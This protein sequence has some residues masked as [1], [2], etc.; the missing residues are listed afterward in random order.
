MT[1]HSG[2]PDPAEALQRT[3]SEHGHLIQA[4]GSTLCSLLD[5]Q[6]QVSQQLEQLT[7][8][9]QHT[10]GVMPA[11]PPEGAEAPPESQHLPHSRE[12]VCPSP[13]KFSGESALKTMTNTSTINFKFASAQRERKMPQ[14]NTC[15]QQLCYPLAPARFIQSQGCKCGL[16]VIMTTQEER[17][18]CQEQDKVMQKIPGSAMC[19]TSHHNFPVLCL[20][21][22]VLYLT[23]K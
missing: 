11:S 10:L 7:A 19:I 9:M 23:Y 17:I 22:D 6:R 13:E 5:Q 20:N 2:Q 21:E 16:C 12:V 14:P 18:Y 15:K 1:E 4:H 8:L 3:V